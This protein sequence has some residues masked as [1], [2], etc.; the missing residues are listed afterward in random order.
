MS[1]AVRWEG[2]NKLQVASY[3]DALSDM[4]CCKCADADAAASA[5][6]SHGNPDG[7]QAQHRDNEY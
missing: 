1:S 7:L 2:V 4:C 3:M 6:G 5:G